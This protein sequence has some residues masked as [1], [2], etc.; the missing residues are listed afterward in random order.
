M[1]NAL[2]FDHVGNSVVYYDETLRAEAERLSARACPSTA[3]V[4]RRPD[5]AMEGGHRQ[6][7]Q[8]DADRI[9][10]A[11]G[12]YVMPGMI[13]RGSGDIVATASIAGLPSRRAC[14]SVGPPLFCKGPSSGSIVS[15]GRTSS[16]I[17]PACRWAP[18]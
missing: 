15:C 17:S 12:M 13:E 4:R 8:M 3:A 7:F 6:N 11:T 9:I 2:T 1:G 5:K 10:D 18:R 16:W 14:V